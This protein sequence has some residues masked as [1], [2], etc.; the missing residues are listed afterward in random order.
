MQGLGT[1]VPVHLAPLPLL[2]LPRLLLLLAAWGLAGRRVALW[3]TGPPGGSLKGFTLCSCLPDLS[4][5]GG[6]GSALL[7]GPN[8]LPG[9]W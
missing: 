8:L 7:S 1:P 5:G 4:W 6:T 9:D 3:G 2:L